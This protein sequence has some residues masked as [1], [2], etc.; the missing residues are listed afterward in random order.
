MDYAYEHVDNLHIITVENKITHAKAY[1]KDI[2]QWGLDSDINVCIFRELSQQVFPTNNTAK[3]HEIWQFF[4]E[5][6][7]D[8]MAFKLRWL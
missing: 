4:F 6:E 8:A 2:F 3:L 7:S 1:M 5:S